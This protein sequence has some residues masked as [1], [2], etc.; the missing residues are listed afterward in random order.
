MANSAVA[1]VYAHLSLGSQMRSLF[2]ARSRPRRAPRGAVAGERAG[3]LEGAASDDWDSCERRGR[4]RRRRRRR[5]RRRSNSRAGEERLTPSRDGRERME[6][7]TGREGGRGRAGREEEGERG[8]REGAARGAN[9]ERAAIRRHFQPP[10]ERQPSSAGSPL[11]GLM[12]PASGGR[13]SA[14][15]RALRAAPGSVRLW[16]RCIPR[17]FQC[18]SCRSSSREPGRAA[19]AAELLPVS[20]PV[21]ALPD[22]TGSRRRQ[23]SRPSAWP[24]RTRPSA[25][26]GA[27]PPPSAPPAPLNAL[28][29]AYPEPHGRGQ[30]P[31]TVAPSE[32]RQ[33]RPRP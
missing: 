20:G 9:G 25:R 11:E 33:P 15:L 18:R 17:T 28:R 22:P 19:A 16:F 21:Q 32:R 29:S 14:L 31:P 6:R 23:H 4:G 2:L 24:P 13:L 30:S 12:E 8:N 7:S 26:P 1:G 10:L 3:G 27:T 5:R